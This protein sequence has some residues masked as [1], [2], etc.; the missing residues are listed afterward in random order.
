[1]LKVISWYKIKRNEAKRE[2]S[3]NLWMRW[4][5]SRSPIKIIHS[6]SLLFENEK[7]NWEWIEFEGVCGPKR[8]QNERIM[9]DKWIFDWFGLI[10][11]WMKHEARQHPP[12]KPTLNSQ[13][14]AALA[15]ADKEWSWLC[16]AGMESMEWGWIDWLFG[17]LWAAAAA[18]QLA[19][20]E[21]SQPHEIDEMKAIELWVKRTK[22]K[23][24]Q[25]IKF[26]EW[27]GMN[28]WLPQPLFAGVSETPP[29]GAQRPA[30]SQQINL[31]FL[32]CGRRSEASK[33]WKRKVN[34]AE[35]AATNQQTTSI[36]PI[37]FI[38]LC[39]WIDGVELIVVLWLR[40]G[41]PSQPNTFHFI[42]WMFGFI[43]TS[44]IHSIEFHSIIKNKIKFYF[45]F[46][47]VFFLLLSLFCY[48]F[49]FFLSWRSEA[50]ERKRKKTI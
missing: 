9:K 27:N 19:K 41:W 28:C 5:L 3:L 45:S 32:L 30:A 48:S 11:S 38:Q 12:A 4:L 33:E 34:L 46:C 8:M 26:M 7:R 42:H 44:P 37:N 17:W 40:S 20:K 14:F 50:K 47:F 15:G 39:E 29:Q 10:N 31:F 21:T 16:W 36:N 6:I 23:R 25:I 18:R 1:M 43:P 2:W 49:L 24:R 22:A 13:F 35:G